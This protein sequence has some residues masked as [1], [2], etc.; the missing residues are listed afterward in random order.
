MSII[1]INNLTKHFGG[2][3]A[4]RNLDLQIPE[5]KITAIIGPN[6]AGKTTLFNLITGSL[7]PDSGKIYFHKHEISSL[8]PHQTA[9]LGIGRTFQDLRLFTNTTVEENIKTALA[10]KE[11]KGFIQNL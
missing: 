9:L 7:K 4:I 11:K 2:I 6:G 5:N 1:T 3:K 10:A 8:P